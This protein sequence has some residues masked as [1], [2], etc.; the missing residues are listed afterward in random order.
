MFICLEVKKSKAEAMGNTGRIVLQRQFIKEALKAKGYGAFVYP[1]N[2]EEIL[3][4]L[5]GF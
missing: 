2:M 3:E 5:Y 4:I 1:E